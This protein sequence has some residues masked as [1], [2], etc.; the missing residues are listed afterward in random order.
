MFRFSKWIAIANTRQFIDVGFCVDAEFEA[1]GPDAVLRTVW[2]Q[3][4][5]GEAKKVGRSVKVQLACTGH[6]ED[7]IAIR[8][9]YVGVG[10][11][12]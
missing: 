11:N 4:V 3:R 1:H 7:G 8:A 9:I 5:A 10:H 12:F 2:R 6:V